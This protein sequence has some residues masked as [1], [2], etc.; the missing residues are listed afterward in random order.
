VAP[1][2]L[3]AVELPAA[4]AEDAARL[5]R[6]AFEDFYG[7]FSSDPERL[8]PAIVAQFRNPSE[9]NQVVA[10]VE[11]GRVVGIGSSYD[12]REMAERQMAGVRLLLEA[13]DD[14]L[15][16]ARA[17]REFRRNFAPPP[18][19]GAYLSRLVVAPERRGS[20]LAAE[21]LARVERR[22]AGAGLPQLSLHVR[23]DNA[24][25]LA[26]YARA[27]YRPADAGDLGYLLLARELR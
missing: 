18:A 26:F 9:L 17:L 23:R 12:A 13:A 1:D 24:R 15:A 25:A 4:Q 14:H 7:L 2:Y 8:F 3:E 22:A 20:G 10:A 5:A 21:L 11:D 16:A 6:L 19:D 27:G